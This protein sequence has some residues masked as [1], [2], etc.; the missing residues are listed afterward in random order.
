VTFLLIDNIYVVLVY[1]ADISIYDTDGKLLQDTDFGHNMGKLLDRKPN[2]EKFRHEFAA[3]NSQPPDGTEIY[4]VSHNVKEAA[5]AV[6]S[7]VT[8][9][10]GPMYR[11]KET[12]LFLD[13][14]WNLF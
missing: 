2:G 4:L 14:G 12:K 10:R 7:E 6:R 8:V 3:I 1:S 5:G 13:I 11:L 9:L